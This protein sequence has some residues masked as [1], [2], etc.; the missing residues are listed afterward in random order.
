[1]H[2]M[3][4]TAKAAKTGQRIGT[5]RFVELGGKSTLGHEPRRSVPSF[6]GDAVE[7]VFAAKQQVAADKGGGG[8]ETVVEAVGRQNLRRLVAAEDLR[9]AV[10]AGD[11]DAAVCGDR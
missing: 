9:H 1:M 6:P 4:A 5:P 3:S 11:V 10:A 7:R 2:G 8:A